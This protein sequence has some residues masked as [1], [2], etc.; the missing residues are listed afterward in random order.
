MVQLGLAA[1]LK[2]IQD[3]LAAVPPARNELPDR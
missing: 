3:P 1:R 2:E